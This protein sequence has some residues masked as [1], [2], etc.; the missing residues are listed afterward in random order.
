MLQNVLKREKNKYYKLMMISILL[1]VLIVAVSVTLGEA[2]LSLKDGYT[3]ILNKIIG[4]DS[5][6]IAEAI[7]WDIRLPRILSGFL[8]GAGLAVAGVIF[9]SVLRN[10]LADPYTIG[11][12]TGAAFGAVLSIYLNMVYG[13]FIP[14][15]PVAFGFSILT[16]IIILRI[17]GRSLHSTRLILAG[18]IVGSIFSAGISLLKSMAGEDVSAMVFWLMGRLTAKSWQDILLLFP[19]IGIGCIIA[20]SK[21]HDLDVL[22]LGINEAR[23]VGVDANKS[24]KVF[25]VVAAM[26]TAV[27]VSTSGVIGFIGL[28]VPHLIRIG[29]TAKHRYLLPLSAVVGGLVLMLSDNISRLMFQVEIPVGVI[30]TLIGGPFFIYIYMNKKGEIL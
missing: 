21:A 7:V 6:S 28:I 4:E 16:L 26:L 17:S 15:T 2:D 25:L 27:C 9:Q 24:A 5:H 13:L 30:T 3:V 22:T 1:C 19:L 23:S 14:I 12:S 8:I 11:V 20:F 29:F 18:I 10:P